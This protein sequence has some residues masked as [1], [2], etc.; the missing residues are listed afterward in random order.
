MT[1]SN[2]YVAHLMQKGFTSQELQRPVA[3]PEVP[4]DMRHIY[5]NWDDY[6]AALHDFLNGN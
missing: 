4:A 6:V 5:N 2:P 3:R 1:H